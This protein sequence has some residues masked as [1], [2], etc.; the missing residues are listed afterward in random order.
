M[1]INI[2]DTALGRHRATMKRQLVSSV[3]TM[4]KVEL[5][6]LRKEIDT[7]MEAETS[8]PTDVTLGDLAVAA[9]EETMEGVAV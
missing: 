6:N 2:E 4:S 5:A 3:A 8:A 7:F 1:R 9:E